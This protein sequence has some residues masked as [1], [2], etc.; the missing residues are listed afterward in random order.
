MFDQDVCLLIKKANITMQIHNTSTTTSWSITL[1][2]ES[3]SV[4]LEQLKGGTSTILH[5]P[6]TPKQAWYFHP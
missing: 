1:H 5:L 3:S 2:H 6:V 4:A